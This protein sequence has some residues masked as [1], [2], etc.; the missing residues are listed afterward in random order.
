MM[1][2]FSSFVLLLQ[3]HESSSRHEG[4]LKFIEPPP[5]NVF[6]WLY[7]ANFKSPLVMDESKS[8]VRSDGHRSIECR[9]D[10]VVVSIFAYFL[11]LGACV[12]SSSSGGGRLFT[13]SAWRKSLSS[14]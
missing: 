10:F 13:R 4:I 9:L 7:T 5:C 2:L 12:W 8:A 14:N 6:S 1:A 11:I 3:S